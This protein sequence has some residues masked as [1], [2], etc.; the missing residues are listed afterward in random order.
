V[1]LIIGTARYPFRAAS[2]RLNFAEKH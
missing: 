1:A 2:Q